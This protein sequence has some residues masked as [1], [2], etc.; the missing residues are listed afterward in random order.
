MLHTFGSIS[1]HAWVF[2]LIILAVI[3]LLGCFMEGGSIM[4]I[5][6]PLLLPILGSYHIDL[7]QFGVVFQLAIMIGLAHPPMGMLLFVVSGVGKVP[8]REIVSH[9]WPFLFALLV[10]LLLVAF[11][12]QITLWLPHL[13]RGGK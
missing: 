10:T 4:I 13:V 1:D 6:T 12:P 9:L 11:I 3:L 5:L 8:V 7:V 2:T